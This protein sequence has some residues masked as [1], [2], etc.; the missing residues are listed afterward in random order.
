MSLEITLSRNPYS[1]ENISSIALPP[2]NTW[3]IC[4]NVRGKREE[5]F[6]LIFI[7]SQCLSLC[8][9]L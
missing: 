9:L 4:K 7:F 5:P 2:C 6:L 8:R 1:P 3:S